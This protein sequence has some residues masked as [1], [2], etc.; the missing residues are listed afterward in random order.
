MAARIK[1]GD[2]VQIIAGKD[3]GEKGRVLQ[4]VRADLVLVESVA[5][6]TQLGPGSEVE[7]GPLPVVDVDDL[8]QESPGTHARDLAD[9]RRGRDARA[10]HRAA[11]GDD[12]FYVTSDAD[13]DLT[14]QPEAH[15]VAHQ[16]GDNNGFAPAPV[17][18]PAPTRG[19]QAE[20]QR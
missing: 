19:G 20:Y 14:N 3:K 12:R 7:V 5:H 18:D 16:A 1:K 13:G 9:D 8:G 11:G 17:A 4:V 10:Y 6:G 15:G 2:L